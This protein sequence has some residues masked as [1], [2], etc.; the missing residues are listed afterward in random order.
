MVAEPA[1]AITS[2]HQPLSARTLTDA[3]VLQS[4]AIDD[5][6]VFQDGEATSIFSNTARFPGAAAAEYPTGTRFYLI[7]LALVLVTTLGGLD[8]NIVATAVP[9]IT[10][11]S[12]LVV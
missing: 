5:R 6:G 10:D 4:L 3:A 9:S 1:Q 12:R 11:V 2:G 8:G 7:C